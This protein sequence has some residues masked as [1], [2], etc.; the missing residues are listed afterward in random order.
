MIISSPN[1]HCSLTLLFLANNKL[2][3]VVGKLSPSDSPTESQSRVGVQVSDQ[4]CSSKALLCLP[5]VFLLLTPH[6]DDHHL[7][8]GQPQGPFPPQLSA[9]TPNILSTEPSTAR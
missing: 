2:K 4:S 9:S 1:V 7:E 3:I 8:W 6:R 5:G